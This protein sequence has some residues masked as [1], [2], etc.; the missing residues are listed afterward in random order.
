MEVIK[1]IDNIVAKIIT[2]L[3]LAC[4]IGIFFVLLANVIIRMFS[5]DYKM[6][7]YAEVVEILF[8]YMVM[9]GATLLCRKS[10]HFKVDLF[11]K[12]YWNVK[13]FYIV[14]VISSIIALVFFV[15]FFV[16]S[17]ELFMNAPQTMPVLQ[18]A[19][20]WGY[21]SMPLNG[22]FLCIYTT[23]DVIKNILKCTGKIELTKV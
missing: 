15:F 3:A 22:V 6:S 18:I 16:Y 20:R 8:A 19:K 12:K 1:K 10:E 17:L 11:L 13:K 5:I 21:L 4:F 7:W 14:E 9:F 2:T 23:K